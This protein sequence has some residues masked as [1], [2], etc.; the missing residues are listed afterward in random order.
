MQEL[1]NKRT[2]AAKHFDNG[3]GTFTARCGSGPIHYKDANGD[4]VDIETVAEDKGTYW[5]FEKANHKLYVAKDFSADQLIRVDNRWEGNNHSIKFDPKRL[6][7]V[8]NPNLSD[9]VV[10]RTAQ[11]VQGTVNGNVITYKDAFGAGIDYELIFSPRAVG[12]NLVINS[13]NALK[14]PPTPNHKLVLL[15]KFEGTGLKLKAKDLDEWD[16]SSYY[17]SQEEVELSE[18]GIVKDWF[19]DPAIWDADDV[20]QPIKVFWKLHNG[21]LWQ[22]KVL[23]KQFLLD[24]TYPVRTDTVIDTY[25]ATNSKQVVYDG[26]SGTYNAVCTSASGNNVY[27]L[28]LATQNAIHDSIIGGNFY[29]RRVDFQFDTSSIGSGNTVS[30]ASLTMY[31]SN[32]GGGSANTNSYSIYLLDNTNNASLASPITT[33]DYGDFEANAANI[34]GSETMATLI[35]TTGNKTVS[36]TDFNVIDVTGTSRIGLRSNNEML[37]DYDGSASQPTGS[38]ILRL[39]LGS[40]APYLDVTYSAGGTTFVPK[41]IFY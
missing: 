40:D 24:A 41:V 38:N 36:M 18:G 5:A 10:F 25:D 30:A 28:N 37:E 35:A 12:K 32:A 4:L 22:G 1:L 20:R 31:V 11:A 15:S 19:R 29:I 34:I 23:P 8:N 16:G 3:D 33:A 9:M 14:L 6:V 26:Y 39:L 7:W 21:A 17:E 13:K 27:T 2:Y